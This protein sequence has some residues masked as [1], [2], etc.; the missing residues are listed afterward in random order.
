MDFEE[1]LRSR[2]SAAPFRSRERSLLKVVLGEIQL[3]MANSKVTEEVCLGIVK[4]MIKS[5]EEN[6][7]YLAMT[8]SRRADYEEENQILA[9]L[10][11]AYLTADQIFCRL[12]SE[13]QIG[14]SVKDANNEG[15]AIG[16]AMGFLKN[17]G[18]PVEGD[19]VKQAVQKI[20]AKS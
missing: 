15:K 2:I 10:L 19:A 4:K 5:N 12:M 6:I 3:K 20:R 8:D 11:P 9:T 1:T 18:L 14:L 7:G 17:A 13:D 16:M